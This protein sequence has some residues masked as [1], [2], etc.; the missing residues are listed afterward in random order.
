V[1]A[2]A[3]PYA[4]TQINTDPNQIWIEWA[5]YRHITQLSWFGL[6]VEATHGN[7]DQIAPIGGHS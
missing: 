4:V 1:S 5:S 2:S 6:F 7:I 3:F